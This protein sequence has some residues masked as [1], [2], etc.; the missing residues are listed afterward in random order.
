MDETSGNRSDSAGS[1]TLADNNTVGYVS[2]KNGN[3]ANIIAANTEYLSITDGSQSGLDLSGS[4]TISAWIYISSY[5]GTWNCIASKYVSPSGGASY[6]F[7]V[8]NSGN[9]HI[10]ISDDGTSFESFAGSNNITLNQWNHVVC[11]FTAGSEFALWINGSKETTG[12][13][14]NS[15]YNSTA[16]FIVGRRHY[17]T[18]P[19]Q[20]NGYIDEIALWNTNI[21]DNAVTALYKGGTGRFYITS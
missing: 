15:V 10:G 17:A 9:L 4:F 3:A 1:N 5:G 8:N 11:R 14:K 13:T 20:Y 6:Q 2:G 19:Y 12:A 7:L 16:D 21:S 18:S